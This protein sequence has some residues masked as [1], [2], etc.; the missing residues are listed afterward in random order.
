M[1]ETREQN[2]KKVNELI[3]DIEIAMLTTIDESGDL[4]ARPMAT[5]KSEFDGDIWFFTYADSHKVDEINSDQRVNV[6]YS[7]PDGN[8]FVSVAGTAELVTDKAKIEELYNPV[9][10]AWFPDGT[11]TP[12]IALLKISAESAQ[13]WDAPHNTIVKIVGLAKATVTGE[14]Y[15]PGENEKVQIK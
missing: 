1:S 8:S 4:H 6:S 15:Q 7:S 2:L 10:K 5:Q 3:S 13:Y 9:L 12:G 14:P 11:A